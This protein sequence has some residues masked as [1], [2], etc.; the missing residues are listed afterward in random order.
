MRLAQDSALPPVGGAPAASSDRFA[1]AIAVAIVLAAL[2]CPA[3]RAAAPAPCNAIVQISD[4][5]GDGHHDNSD[6][7][8]AWFSEQAGRLQAVVK[9]Q[10]GDWRPAHEDSESVGFAVLYEVGGQRR[11]VRLAAPQTGPLRF[12]YGTWT[13]AGGFASA[14]STSGEVAAG[15]GGTVTID[16]PA[17][18]GAVAGTLLARPFVLTYDGQSAPA[19]EHWVDR[20]PGGVTP[21]EDAF[22]ADYV[23]GSCQPGLPGGP[24]GTGP[25]PGAGATATTAVVLGAPARLTGSGKARASGRI[26]PARAGV[27]VTITA[28]PQR[29]RATP[30]TRSVTTLPDGTFASSI[31]LNETSRITAI[32]EGVNAQTVTVVVRSTIS[33]RLRRLRAGRTSVSGAVSPR[34]P[35]RVLLLR[36][37]AVVPSATTT[38]RGGRFRIPAR[39]FV[40]GRYQAV[41]IPT[42]NR[43]E[44]S[45]SKTGAIR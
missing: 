27:A 13:I 8:S 42:G 37:N 12:D 11:F 43:A 20:G 30:T 31:S 4:P 14:G 19:E 6:V 28:T 35:G 18:T 25:G 33:L 41:F 10:L 39:R 9:V 15:L 2:L 16:V 40:R 1:K 7:L 36:S 3:A 26:V 23:V 45:T 29:S 21:G 34:L 17:A 38:A 32:A 22:G 44:R 24:A 5:S